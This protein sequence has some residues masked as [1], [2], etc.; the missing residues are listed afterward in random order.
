MNFDELKNQWG[1]E[2]TPDQSIPR[3]N[4]SLNQ[5]NNAIDKVRKNMRKDFYGIIVLFIISLMVILFVPQYIFVHQIL[6]FII[7]SFF[8]TFTILSSYFLFKFYRF[9]K[10]SYTLSYSM[11]DNLWWFYYE[12]RSFIDFYYM[13]NV[14]ALTMGFSCGLS[15]GYIGANLKFVKNQDNVISQSMDQLGANA[16]LFLIV[17]IV[18]IIGGMIGLHYAVKYMY[19][20]HLNQLKRTLDLLREQ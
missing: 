4:R 10:K 6:Q 7:W 15:L 9:Y 13:F 12:L 3:L 20:K 16:Y 19:G 18:I 5:A 14:V 11:K 1:Q 8:L 2:S 17:M